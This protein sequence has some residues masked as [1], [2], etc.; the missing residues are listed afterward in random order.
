MFSKDLVEKLKK[1][2][3]EGQVIDTIV[4]EGL[5]VRIIPPNATW[6]E[7]TESGTIVHTNEKWCVDDLGGT[8]REYNS[9]EELLEDWFLV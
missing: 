5:E 3:K 4:P 2:Q 1:G 8:L 6:Q 9:L 7:E